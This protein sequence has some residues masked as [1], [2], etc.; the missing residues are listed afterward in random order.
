MT[1]P[2]ESSDPS[3]SN[4]DPRSAALK[5][6]QF[7]KADDLLLNYIGP[8]TNN[9]PA[10]YAVRFDGDKPSVIRLD[11]GAV[12]LDTVLKNFADGMLMGIPDRQSAQA[13]ADR[14][15]DGTFRLDLTKLKSQVVSWSNTRASYA[16]QYSTVQADPAAAIAPAIEGTQ[17]T[18]AH[19]FDVVFSH[20]SRQPPNAGEEQVY[21]VHCGDGTSPGAP[22]DVVAAE[23]SAS[24]EAVLTLFEAGTYLS[25]LQQTTFPIGFTCYLLNTNYF[26]LK[27]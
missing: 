5:P 25:F 12:G 24:V 27:T 23:D 19:P 6:S 4:S 11:N 10:V 1:A 13:N 18:I 26:A 2:T 17:G 8:E 15:G 14:P 9:E 21:I 22:H 20:V 16:R 7:I 3:P